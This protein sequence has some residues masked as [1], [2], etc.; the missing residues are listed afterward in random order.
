MMIPIKNNAQITFTSLRFYGAGLKVSWGL[1]CLVFT[2]I[3]IISSLGFVKSI[4]PS[5]PSVCFGMNFALLETFS[6]DW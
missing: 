6:N 2:G 5:N 3:G 4:D 1:D